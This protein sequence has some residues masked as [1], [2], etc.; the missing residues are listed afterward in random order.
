MSSGVSL[1]NVHEHIQSRKELPLLLKTMDK[2]EIER[3]VL[4]GSSA[5][6]IT[7]DYRAGF[8]NYEANNRE[9]LCIRNSHPD[10]IE[11]WPT[12]YPLARKKLEKLRHYVDLGASGLKLY[13]GH[14]FI[15]PF[16]QRYLFSPVAIDH[17]CM[18][19]IYEYC[20]KHHL[21]ICLHVNPGPGVPGFAAEFVTFLAKR[22]KL[23]VNAPHWI[24][25]A[26]SPRRLC[27]LLDVFPNLVTDISLGVDEFLIKG[28]RCISSNATHLRLVIDRHPERFMFGTDFVVTRA[29]H[30][31][32]DWMEVRVQAYL[33]M[34]SFDE[35]RTPLIPGEVLT[36]LALPAA[37][38]KQVLG[39]N[40]RR[41][42]ASGPPS[43]FPTRPIEWGE[44]G[45]PRVFRAPGERLQPKR[46]ARF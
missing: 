12:L 36:G 18:D 15:A 17:P 39:D 2:S 3:V 45:V 4:L 43:V 21:P 37:T 11:A 31:T 32:T 28:L 23:L 42:R 16:E 6:T 44:L 34:L 38:L 30:K 10:R 22:P 41:F 40:F 7:S 27:E 19:E 14:G 13:I 26:G 25:S 8:T 29:R 20:A 46:A 9:I 5:F 35:Y 1:I 33:S 24:L